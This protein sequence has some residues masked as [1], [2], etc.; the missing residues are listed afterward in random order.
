[1]QI[2]SGAP[3]AVGLTTCYPP[4]SSCSQSGSKCSALRSLGPRRCG[5]EGDLVVWASQ[6]LHTHLPRLAPWRGHSSLTV[7]GESTTRKTAV[8][9]D[10]SLLNWRRVGRYGLSSTVGGIFVSHWSAIARL[11]LGSPRP[12]RC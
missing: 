10:K 12:V 4:G 5:R 7:F 1:M 6:G 8:T 11:Q 9:S 3:K 2:W